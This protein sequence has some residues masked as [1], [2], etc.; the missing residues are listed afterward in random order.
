VEILRAG[1]GR[2]L[3]QRRRVARG[4]VLHGDSTETLVALDAIGYGVGIPRT[5]QGYAGLVLDA[6]W[7]VLVAI[8][9]VLD[10]RGLV[11]SAP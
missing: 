6:L 1:F 4:G 3:G 10:S 8:V 11:M 2:G 5:L 9:T 7:H